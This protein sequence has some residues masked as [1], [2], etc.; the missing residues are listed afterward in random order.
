MLADMDRQI[1]AALKGAGLD[2]FD[3]LFYR[4]GAAEPAECTVT[5]D[6]LELTNEYGVPVVESGA[7]IGYLVAEVR[8]P[9]LGDFFDFNGMR[10]TIE[11][12]EPTQDSSWRF[13]HCRE[14]SL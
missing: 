3:A 12:K 1:M 2:T 6:T 8:N 5:L 10:Y 7:R 4:A 9:A 14:D 13:V 11:N